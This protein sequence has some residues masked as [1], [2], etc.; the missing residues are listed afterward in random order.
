MQMIIDTFR[1]HQNETAT[2]AALGRKYE[3]Q[4]PVMIYAILA[5]NPPPGSIR[6]VKHKQFF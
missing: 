1:Q 3:Y 2:K 6:V 4:N 5:L